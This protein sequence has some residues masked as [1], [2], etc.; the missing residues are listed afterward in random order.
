MMRTASAWR[1]GVTVFAIAVPFNFLWEMAQSSLYVAMPP[2]PERVWHCFI[3]SLG[4]GVMVL[5][6][7]IAGWAV[8]R[9]KDWFR[10]ADARAYLLI[11]GGGLLLAV[12]VE[13][14]ALQAD[15]WRYGSQMPLVRGPGV[16]PLAQMALLPLV[17]LMLAARTLRVAREG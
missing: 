7:W 13:W 9:A 12:I 14:L 11:V 15:R 6:I 8:F 1:S 5:L 17:T 2:F 10:R 4:D 16:V 3:A